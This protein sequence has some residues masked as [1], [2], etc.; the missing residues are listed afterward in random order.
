MTDG[1]AGSAHPSLP[2]RSELE[3]GLAQA[4][5]LTLRLIEDLS[6]DELRT[7]YDP[8]FSPIGWHV[9]HV[10][11]QEECWVLRR[12]AGQPPLVPELDGLWNSFSSV[13]ARRGGALQ[14]RATLL[15]YAH[16]VRQR[17]LEVLARVPFDDS[18]LLTDGHVF[19]FLANH[20]RQHVEIIATVRLLGCLFLRQPLELPV[21]KLRP[22]E[23]GR[24]RLA[25]V[26]CTT[27][28]SDDP[29]AWDN[30]RPARQVSVPGFE[31]ARHPVGCGEWLEFMAAGGYR[32]SRW[33]C[34][35]GDRFRREHRLQAPL[36][37]EPDGEGGWV[38]R[39]LRGIAAVA[40][41][42]PVCHVSWYEALA[43]ARFA[44]A[45]LP[46]E[47]EWE[48]AASW[49]D[50][51]ASKRRWPWGA[52]PSPAPGNLE[53]AWGDVSAGCDPAGAAW[54]G[55]LDL[56]GQVWEW[57]ADAFEG[58]PGFVPQPYREY[59]SPWFDGHHRVAR[60]GSYMTALSMARTTFRNWYLP[61]QR[62]PVLGLRLVYD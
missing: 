6:D 1:S 25:P 44:G 9:G 56:A 55:V 46:T 12:V 20:E 5:G 8:E 59:S 17:T 52:Q 26:A 11:W 62:Q 42:A 61:H 14:D 35:A 48:R 30:E 29:E 15:A 49:D 41:D 45:R 10:A 7:Q 47:V 38:R 58:Y 50:A 22:R 27:G 18:A 43:F 53:L 24:V 39:S 21:T 28:T 54:S 33:W 60:G 51:S 13:K 32:E 37:W 16:L 23:R 40:P 36:F 19:R 3:Q 2:L 57:T 31:L 4:R 34:A